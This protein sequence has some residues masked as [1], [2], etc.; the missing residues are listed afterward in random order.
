VLV[1]RVLV[2]EV[3]DDTARDGL[4]RREHAP[5][6]A[7]VVH[8][9]QARVQAGAGAQKAQQ[10]RLVRVRGKEVLD[11]EAFGVLPDERERRVGYIAAGIDRRL[12]GREPC[13]RLHRGLPGVDED[14]AVGRLSEVGSDGR[15]RR[16]PDPAQRA[17]DDPRVPEVVA[18]QPFDALLRKRP[19]VPEDVGGLFLQR[20]AELVRV[21]LRLEVENRADAQQEILGL[22]Q[23]R[24]VLG[25]APEERRIGQRRDP[26]DRRQVAQRAGRV[27][28]VRLEL[29]ER[30]VEERVALVDER[31]QRAD[32]VRVGAGVVERGFEAA[33]EPEVA[34]DRPRVD[35]CHEELGVVHLEAG[36]LVDL[37][38]LVA[39][40]EAE[41]PERV[42][43]GAEQPLFGLAKMAAEEDEEVDVRMQAQLLAAV[44]ADRDDRH[45]RHGLGSGRRIENVAEEPIEAFGEPRERGATA[46]PEHDVVAQ[47][48]PRLFQQHGQAG[49]R[50]VRFVERAQVHVRHGGR[51]PPI[52]GQP[53]A[54]HNL[55]RVASRPHCGLR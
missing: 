24:E 29:I 18:H 15:R 3:A 6:D 44:P 38:D 2:E 12:E 45:R 11:A 46:V 1:D 13:R 55:H 35:Q 25:P 37:P 19:R 9:R 39:H 26:A 17:R 4:K 51:Q 47:L 33:V 32:D 23:P 28:D 8:L 7:A 42:Q 36:E 30:R 27:L 40:H 20:V 41:I 14:D 52:E 21:P 22:V 49:G 53:D 10:R 48:A 34:R 5:E 50:G 16:L 31:V 43:D 54:L